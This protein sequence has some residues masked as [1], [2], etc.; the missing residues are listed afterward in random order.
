MIYES[1]SAKLL[2]HKEPDEILDGQGKSWDS[3]LS[4]N[5]THRPLPPQKYIHTTEANTSCT[6]TDTQTLD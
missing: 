5:A 6:A 2:R 4:D 3:E 1:Y